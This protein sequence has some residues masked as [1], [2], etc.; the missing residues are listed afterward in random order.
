[1]S[2]EAVTSSG[3]ERNLDSATGGSPAAAP[4]WWNGK[5]LD[6]T[7][8]CREYL[9]GHDIRCING[10][11]FTPDGYCQ[12]EDIK[13]EIYGLIK[14]CVRS[15]PAQTAGHIVE[16]LKIEAKSKA[17]LVD[18]KALQIEVI[19]PVE[20]RIARGDDSDVFHRILLLIF[21]GAP[22]KAAGALRALYIMMGI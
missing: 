11:F 6:T 8:F 10:A 20:A 16:N 18:G 2:D 14:D 1:M 4:A 17:L 3:A 15:F 5:K 7:A 21:C 9:K 22:A 19:E 13:A 12:T